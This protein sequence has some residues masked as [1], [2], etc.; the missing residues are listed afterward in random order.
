[1][2][3]GWYLGRRQGVE[4]YVGLDLG[5]APGEGGTLDW[6]FAAGRQPLD[7]LAASVMVGCRQVALDLCGHLGRQGVERRAQSRRLRA[8]IPAAG[9]S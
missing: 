8:G 2:A 7:S 9:G 3:F 6:Y 4:Q 1:M 5:T